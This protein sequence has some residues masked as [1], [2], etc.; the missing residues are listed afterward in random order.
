MVIMGARV[1]LAEDEKEYVVYPAGGSGPLFNVKTIHI[2]CKSD[3]YLG[4]HHKC[5][6]IILYGRNGKTDW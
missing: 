5:G 6:G 4:P 1:S 3:T 2:S